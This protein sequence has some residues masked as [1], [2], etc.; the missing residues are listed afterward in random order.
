MLPALDLKCGHFEKVSPALN[1]DTLPHQTEQLTKSKA[2]E[3][4]NIIDHFSSL[5]S[6]H[7][8]CQL[9]KSKE[10]EMIILFLKEKFLESGCPVDWYLW[11]Y[12][13]FG[14]LYVFSLFLSV[15]N[16]LWSSVFVF[17]FLN[18]ETALLNTL[19]VSCCVNMNCWQVADFGVRSYSSSH[20]PP[21]ACSSKI[22]K[23]SGL[24][25]SWKFS[26]KY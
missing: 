24:Q 5:I 26:L 25:W 4:I 1:S 8:V 20:P 9:T 6:K 10:E 15:S 18:T 23:I 2:G 12:L 7:F 17:A 13:R 22:F 14:M 16:P 21:L 3:M 19:G 11:C